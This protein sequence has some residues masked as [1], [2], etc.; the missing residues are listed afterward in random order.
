MQYDFYESYNDYYENYQLNDGVYIFFLSNSD[1]QVLDEAIWLVDNKVSIRQ[2]SKEF[3][4][5]KSSVHRDIHTRLRNL[6]FE[7]YCCV[8]KQLK[9]NKSKYFR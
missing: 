9:K 7:L 4:R 2:V 6:S 5:T 1:K 3:G 8:L